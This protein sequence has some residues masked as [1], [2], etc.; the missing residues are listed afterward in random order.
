MSNVVT[1]Y[2]GADI[3]DGS[4]RRAGHALL[5]Q[6]AKV[7]AIVPEADIPA[8][9]ARIRLEG[10][11]IAPGFVDVQV[12]GG[13][14]V[15]F[16]DAPTP[17]SIET[18][19]KAHLPFGT[20][21]LITTLVTD[22]KDKTQAA[23]A[24][25]ETAL[26]G[27]IGLHLEGPHLS[28][29]RK[30]AHDPEMIRPMNADD[31][32]M[33]VEA[34][35]SLPTLFLTVAPESVTPAQISQLTAAGA[36]VSL[37]HSDAQP[38][39]LLPLIEAG[40]TAAT[41]LFNAMSQLQNRHPGLVGTALDESRISASVI[42]D[43]VHIHPM[44]LRVALR[45]KRGPGH[46]FLI[47]DAMSTIGTDLRSFTLNGRTITRKNGTLRLDD[48]TLAGADLDM[49]S[50]V[51]FMHQTIGVALEEA[52]RMAA[53][54]PAQ[55]IGRDAEIGCLKAGTKADFI[56]LSDDLAVRQVY[57]TGTAQL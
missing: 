44:T 8:Q 26:P 24:A 14:G 31:V 29:P 18:I 38:D 32:A 57:Q 9:A 50:A 56:W 35:Q 40:A 27:H 33:L 21:S 19:T 49:I 43:G 46:I 54:Y 37:G 22:T 53:L 20:T 13:G 23:I 55:L 47:T 5:I 42:A 2:V 1:A 41:H 12:N 17:A 3:F 15:L 7:Q 45:A 28:R 10:G 52:L 34:A 30:G 51:R 36:I 6:G 48:G 16:N 11:L 39:T 25:A 4:E